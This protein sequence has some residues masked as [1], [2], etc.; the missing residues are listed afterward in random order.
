MP[1]PFAAARAA[2]PD[3]LRREGILPATAA[4]PVLLGDGRPTRWM[5]DSLRVTLTPRGAELAGRCLLE[6]IS[7][8]EGRQLATYGLTGVPLLESCILQSGGRYQGLL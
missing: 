6:L 4:A 5:L 1:E 3:L 2:L 7:R 8:F